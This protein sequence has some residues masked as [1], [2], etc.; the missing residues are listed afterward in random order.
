MRQVFD[1]IEETVSYVSLAVMTLITF[2][3]VIM[4]QFA[5]LSLSFTE[6]ISVNMFVLVTLMGT[7]IAAKR[8]EH[9]SVT[10]LFERMPFRMQ[11]F[12]RIFALVL[13]NIYLILI[14]FYGIRMVAGELLLNQKTPTMQWP[15]WIF[16]SFVV[17]GAIL[18]FIRHLL[19]LVDA[20]KAKPGDVL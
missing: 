6:E 20:F 8:K 16:G 13:T 5:G 3:N 1:K 9:L 2:A 17:I 11:K 19:R 7:S 4:R 18:I 10:V 14:I 12:C 15:E